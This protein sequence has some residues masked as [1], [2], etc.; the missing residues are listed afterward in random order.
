MFNKALLLVPL[1]TTGITQSSHTLPR[2]VMFAPTVIK[3]T[4]LANSGLNGTSKRIYNPGDTGLSYKN[5]PWQ[6]TDQ[7]QNI[8]LPYASAL[9]KIQ[10]DVLTDIASRNPKAASK[11][12]SRLEAVTVLYENEIRQIAALSEVHLLDQKFEGDSLLN[13]NIA[14]N[15]ELSAKYGNLFN[16]IDRIYKDMNMD[17][18]R[19]IWL[20]TIY[21]STSLLGVSM[22]LNAFKRNLKRQPNANKQA[23]FNANIEALRSVLNN[24]Y[25]SF[26]VDADRRILRKMIGEAATFAPNQRIS[27]IQKIISK[28]NGSSEGLDQFI[29]ETFGFS[30][31]KDENYV[32]NTLLKSPASIL[33]YNDAMLVFEKDLADQ[34]EQLRPLEKQR[35]ALLAQYL[36]KYLE[37]KSTHPVDRVSSDADGPVPLLIGMEIKN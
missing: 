7:Q 26:D 24:A 14:A 32:L 29:N 3:C 15:N 22:H 1:L 18:K 9:L 25:A 23:F 10:K 28:Q 5:L 21:S 11:L 4:H 37:L 34:I 30:K 19:H 31:L 13:A 16:D 12:A 35:T 36:A 27:P 8:S 33:N 17:L 20:T 6:F 2:K